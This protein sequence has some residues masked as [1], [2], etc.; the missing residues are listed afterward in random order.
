LRRRR[1]NTL[2][3]ELGV[4][5]EGAAPLHFDTLHPQVRSRA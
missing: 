3:E 5:A 1:N 4:P 2:I